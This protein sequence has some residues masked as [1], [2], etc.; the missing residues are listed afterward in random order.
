MLPPYQIGTLKMFSRK[1]AKAQSQESKNFELS[2]FAP[3]REIIR[4]VLPS[5]L[6]DYHVDKRWA[7]LF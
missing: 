2:V 5:V 3:L 4:L 7:G 6:A 1:G